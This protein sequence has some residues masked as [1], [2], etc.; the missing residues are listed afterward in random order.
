TDFR[1]FVDYGN[2][3]GLD[4]ALY[5]NSYFYHTPLDK[6]D[7]VTPGTIQHMG[8]NSLALFEFLTSEADLTGLKFTSNVIYY[9]LLGQYF[10]VYEWETAQVIHGATVFIVSILIIM[11]SRK[12]QDILSLGLGVLA[13]ALSLILSVAVPNIIAKVYT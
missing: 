3:T 5:K 11:E 8:D 9:D 6:L 4:M 1:Q 13:V 2:L 12:I 10:I 7:S